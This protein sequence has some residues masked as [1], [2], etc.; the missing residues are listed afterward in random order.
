MWF[1][2]TG[3]MG[4]G[5]RQLV[6]F[7][8]RSMG[9]GNFGGKCGMPHCNQCGVCNVAVQKCVNHRICSS[10][11]CVEKVAMRPVPKLLYVISLYHISVMALCN[12]LSWLPVEC[13]LNHII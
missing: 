6:E 12:R 9:V 1:G 7:G 8:D 10:G 2:K 4:T 3:Q 11:W 13:S 5:M